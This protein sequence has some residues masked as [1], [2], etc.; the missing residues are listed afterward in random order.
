[1]ILLCTACSIIGCLGAPMCKRAEVSWKSA[2]EPLGVVALRHLRY[3]DFPYG[4]MTE[5]A[6]FPFA[7]GLGGLRPGNEAAGHDVE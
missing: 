7:N 5:T 4:E 3:V 6:A 1:M 2:F